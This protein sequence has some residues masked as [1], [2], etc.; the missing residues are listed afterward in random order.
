MGPVCGCAELDAAG[1][2]ELKRGEL[3][4]GVVREFGFMM[5]NCEPVDP[6]ELWCWWEKVEERLLSTDWKGCRSSPASAGGGVRARFSGEAWNDWNCDASANG[7][8]DVREG[9]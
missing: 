7:G 4:E 5:W 6:A 8:S 9:T 3:S 2:A 1:L